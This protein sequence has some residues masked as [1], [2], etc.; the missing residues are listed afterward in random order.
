[1]SVNEIDVNAVNE[2]AK[3]M[4]DFFDSVEPAK[5]RVHKA[6]GEDSVCVSCEG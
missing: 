2:Q 6:A 3:S 5:V 1:M 4:D